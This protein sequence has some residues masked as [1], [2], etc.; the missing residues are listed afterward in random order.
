L[1]WRLRL[2]WGSLCKRLYQKYE[3]DGVSDSAAVLGYYFVFS[4]FPFV[5][6]LAA[7]AAYVPHVRV[8]TETLLDRARSFLPSEAM[9]IIATNLRGLVA[10]PRPHLLTLGL[11]AA[12]YS[13][14][15]GVDAVRKALNLAYDVK[16]SRPLWKTE[17]I[18]FGVTVGGGIL[19]LV[20]IA[21][22]LGGG[23][24]GLWVARHLEIGDEYVR[25][26]RLIR[27]PVT[28]VV[29]TL[30]AALGYYLL[31]NVEQRFKFITPGSVIGT[32]FWFLAS[33][34]FGKYVSNFGS[35]NV[36]YGSIG[37]VIVLL[38]WFYITGF[39]LLMG[40]ELNV[41]I[42]QATPDGKKPGARKFDQAPP[43]PDERPSAV[44]PGA[45]KSAS[46]AKRSRGGRAVDR[47]E[48]NGTSS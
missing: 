39:I 28:T 23:G 34:G 14:S 6:V 10:S 8:S 5:F 9:G 47:S 41:I 22:L 26:L 31:P 45:T 1:W 17:L 27:W 30:G 29:I 16:E 11:A 38:T 25:V 40:G 37:G 12:L 35:Y 20:G 21:V 3:E 7:L 36:T 2:N 32:L 4:L 18:A 42:E 15:R 43:P 13:A 48:G 19:V 46:V 24:V 44:P 33:W